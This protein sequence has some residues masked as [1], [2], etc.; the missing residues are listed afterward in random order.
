MRKQH[1]HAADAEARRLQD[2]I[3]HFVIGRTADFNNAMI[4]HFLKDFPG[5]HDCNYT[6]RFKSEVWKDLLVMVWRTVG[7]NFKNACM[8][9][10]NIQDPANIT[11]RPVSAITQVMCDAIAALPEVRDNV[12]L[13]N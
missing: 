13:N 12:A 10:Y 1:G 3:I 11:S 9:P 5:D 4:K 6:R 2:D 8:I 7:P